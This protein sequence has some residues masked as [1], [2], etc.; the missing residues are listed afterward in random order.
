MQLIDLMNL[1]RREVDDTVA[2]YLWSDLEV[3]DF[4]NDAQNEACRR[5]RLIVDS[6]TPDICQLSVPRANEGLVLL[7][8]RVLFVRH[9]SLAGRR[10]LQRVTIDDLEKKHWNWREY[11]ASIPVAFVTDYDTGKLLLWP[12]PDTDVVL[13]L[14]VVRLPRAEMNDGQDRPEIA[15]RL[16][17]SLRYWMMFRAYSKQDS[18]ANDPKK[19]ADSLALFEQEFGKKSSAIDETWI[20][21]EQL[22]DDGTF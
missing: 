3:I 10:A 21:R 14:T 9:A 2:P 22:D 11:P 20:E 16:H 13:N 17:R 18:Q 5:A 12:K 8:E 1:F 15:P 7:D 4:A 19:A 6:T